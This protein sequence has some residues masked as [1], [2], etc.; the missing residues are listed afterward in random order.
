MPAV[1]AIV[2]GEGGRRGQRAQPHASWASCLLRALARDLGTLD[3][4]GQSLRGPDLLLSLPFVPIQW[5]GA[6]V[7]KI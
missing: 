1:A 5:P 2:S 4:Q 3:R 6:G 7:G